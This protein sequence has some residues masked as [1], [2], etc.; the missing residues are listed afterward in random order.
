MIQISNSLSSVFAG[1][2]VAC[3]VLVSA[4]ALPSAN[5]HAEYLGLLAGR[6]ATPARTTD[7][8]V[9]LG[10]VNGDLEDVDYQNIAARVNYRLSPEVVLAGTVGISEFGSTDGVPLGLAVSYYLANQR[11]S[12]K[13]ELAG[14]ASYHF[15]DFSHR[16]L[17]GDIDSLALEV[18]ISGVNPLLDNGLAWYSNFGFHRVTLDIDQTGTANRLNESVNELGIGAGL[19]LPTGLG[20]AYLGFEHIGEFSVGLGIRYFVQ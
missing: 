17:D 8:S 7:L 2:V 5:A 1:K 9:E 15:G 12:R 16:D 4:L 20:E 11:I 10:F 19:I 3:A 13:V 14:R 6:E 18:L